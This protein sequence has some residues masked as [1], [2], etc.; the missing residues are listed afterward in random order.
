MKIVAISDLHGHLPEIPAC[1]LLLIAGD[2]C[3][4]TDHSVDFQRRWLGI[5]FRMWLEAVP[6]RKIVGVWGNHDI[7]A[8]DAPPM[9]PHV[10][11]ITLTDELVE[12][13]GLRIYGLPWQRRFFDWAFNLDEPELD[14]KYAAIPPCDIIVSHGPPLGVGDA[15]RQG[16]QCGSARFRDKIQE[17]RP[18]LVVYGHIHEG[19]GEYRFVQPSLNKTIMANVSIM[20]HKY[21]PRNAPKIFEIDA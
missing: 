20:D 5:V 6:A 17:I 15:N 18:K 16:E 4:L 10:P 3:P 12:W 8:E 11:W 21:R 9:V 7:I 1:D 2:V 19:Y 13:E 14:N